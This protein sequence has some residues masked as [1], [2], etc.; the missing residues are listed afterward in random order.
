MPAIELLPSGFSTMKGIYE[1][2]LLYKL[3][4]GVFTLVILGH[5]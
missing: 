1:L 5:P 3:L 2:E 4:L